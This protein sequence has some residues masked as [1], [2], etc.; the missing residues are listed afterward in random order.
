M[1]D[2]VLSALAKALGPYMTGQKATGT[3][4]VQ[5]L[6]SE[7]GLFGRCDGPSTLINAMIGPIG[8]EKKLMW[9]GTDTQR[10]FVDALTAINETGSE[11]TTGCGDCIKMDLKACA[12]IY[13]FGRFCRQT[14]ELLFDEI[15]LKANSNVPVRTLFGNITDAM[16]NVLVGNGQQITDEFMLQSRAVGYGLRLKNSTVMWSGN[17]A[18]NSGKYLEYKGFN[19]LIN[20]GK[21]DAYTEESCSALDSFLM[22]YGYNAVAADGTYAIR[23]WFHRMVNQFKH[24]AQRAG[25]DWDTANMFIAM[26]PNL[27]ECIAMVYACVGVDLCAVTGQNRVNVS[28]DQ[29]QSRYEN[30]LSSMRLP[31]DGREYEVVTDSQISESHGQANGSCS[32][33]QFIT[34]EINGEEITYGQYQDFNQTYGRVR[35][36]LVSMFGSDDIAITDN[37]RYALIRDNSRG[38]F[39]VQAVTKPRIVARMPWLM[40]RIRN[41][42][43][44]VTQEPYPDTSGSNRVYEKEGGRDDTPPPVLYG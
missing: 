37:G 40:G 27:W 11:Q 16:G 34:T 10:E 36:E 3:P 35:Q 14:Q 23:K 22:N 8:V 6:Y 28:A 25:L 12:Q 43:C 17:P 2:Q 30:Y 29:A 1:S 20:T 9:Y 19:F 33:I 32:D 15:G 44:S 41:V 4:T 26:S 13:P 39:D 7:L 18:N 42:C 38:C 21:Y 24:R 5:G 31:I